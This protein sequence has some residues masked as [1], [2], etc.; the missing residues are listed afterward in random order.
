MAGITHYWDGTV[1]YITTD[2]GTTGVDLKGA[3][4]DVGVRGAQGEK[5]EPYEA[6]SLYPIGSIYI[7]TIDTSPALLLGG[8]WEQITEK[9]LLA[10][11]ET[12]AAGTT[13]G[14][15]TEILTTA[16]MPAHSH[17]E[18]LG[19]N[20]G[21]GSTMVHTGSGG[22][23]TGYAPQLSNS[24]AFVYRENALA[25]YT[26]MAGNGEAHNNMPPYLSVYMWKRIN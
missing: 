9:F 1:L 10:A 25:T 3:K 24:S 12:Y 16:Q 26:D 22:T 11:G 17:L 5:G 23:R 20:G 8:T 21:W 2:S 19:Q 7:S 18:R 14:S 4:G 15:A 13:G 6:L